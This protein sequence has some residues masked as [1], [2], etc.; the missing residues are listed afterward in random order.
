[1]NIF[2][3]DQDIKQC[4]QYHCDQHV[5]K[6]ILESVQ[7][8]CT[9]LNKKGFVTPYKSTH[10]KHPCVLW[11]EASYDNFIWLRDLTIELNKE[12]KY[13]YGKDTDHK[14]MAVLPQIA[15]LVFP[16]I[17]LTPFPQ[18]MPDIYKVDDDPILAYRQF[19]MGDKAKFAKWTKRSPPQWFII[20]N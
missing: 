7:M 3:L 6:M 9:A 8:L 20:N 10:I 16:S 4:A 13:R 11:V 17:G 15:D 19:Y 18:A 14:S 2:I 1:M 5:V 12:Y